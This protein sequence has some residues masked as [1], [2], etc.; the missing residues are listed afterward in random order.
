M[1]RNTE[2]VFILAGTVLASVGVAMVEFAGGGWLDG[3][4]MQLCVGGMN[5]ANRFEFYFHNATRITLI[6]FIIFI[7]G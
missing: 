2:A 1:T 7:I 3:H 6:E 5:D 4:A